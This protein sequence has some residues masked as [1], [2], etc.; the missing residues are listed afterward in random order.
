MEGQWLPSQAH[1]GAFV[2]NHGSSAVRKPVLERAISDE[3]LRGLV[4]LKNGPS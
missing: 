1:V 2:V 3:A 4:T